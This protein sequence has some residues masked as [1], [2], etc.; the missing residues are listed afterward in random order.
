MKFPSGIIASCGCSYGSSGPGFL[1]VTG[2]SGFLEFLPA[3]N[4]DGLRVF[5][6]GDGKPVEIAS[7]EKHPYQFTLEADY[8]A[9]CIR[10]NKQPT[11]GGEEGLKDMLAIEAIYRAAGKPIA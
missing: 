4:Y 8:F 9:D 5:G 2:D 1:R 10:N 11:P 6:G 7:S 3:F